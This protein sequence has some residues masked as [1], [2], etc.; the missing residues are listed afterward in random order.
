MTM[1]EV[2]SRYVARSKRPILLG[3]WRDEVGSETLY[4]LPFIQQWCHTYGIKASRLVAISRGGAAQWYGAGKAVELYDYCPAEALRLETH[5]ASA[6]TGS[7]KQTQETPF[8]RALY[9]IIAQRLGLR[10]YH[11][12]HP[13]EMYAQ[14]NPWMTDRM[15]LSE[16]MSRLRFTRIPTPHVP[17]NIE[18]PEKFVCVR[19]YERH[20]WPFTE[21]VKDYCGQIV[22]QLAKQ[23]P[24]VVIGSSVHH[25]DHLD[26]AF[27]GPNIT[28]LIDAFPLRDNLALQSSVMAK[29]TAFVGTYGGT[30]QLAARLGKPSAG[31]YLQWSGTAYAHK[32]LTEYLGVSQRVP[33]FIGTPQQGDFIRQVI[34]LALEL[35]Q[36]AASSSGVMA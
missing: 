14:L 17:L 19:F 6:R 4:W 5:R 18:L 28:N 11:T 21:E 23:A 24:V 13:K 29:A 36:P 26:M 3:P 27:S 10:R 7:V 22:G 9:P 2:W 16:I 30:M 34:S 33:I 12:I 1:F 8:E 35:P 32:V 15:S 20:T 31:L 25:D